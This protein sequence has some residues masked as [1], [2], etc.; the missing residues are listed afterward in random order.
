ML[1][2]LAPVESNRVRATAIATLEDAK[3]VEFGNVVQVLTLIVPDKC[4]QH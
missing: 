1:D 3:H 2:L 4:V